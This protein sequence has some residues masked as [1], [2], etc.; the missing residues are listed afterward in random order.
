[1]NEFAEWIGKMG[2]PSPEKIQLFGKDP[3]GVLAG[4]PF[5]DNNRPS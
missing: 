1:M 2:G 3:V 4:P 5:C